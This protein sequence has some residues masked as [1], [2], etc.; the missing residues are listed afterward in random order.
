MPLS[1]KQK[2]VLGVTTIVVLV[3]IGLSV[4][5]IGTL[6]RVLLQQAATRAE[7][8]AASVVHQTGG[9]VLSRETAYQDIRSSATVLSALESAMYSPE[10]Q[11]AAILDLSRTVV[12]ANDPA[13]V[14]RT[15]ARGEDLPALVVASGYEQVRAVY[16]QGR[17]LEWR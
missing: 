3:V 9:A 10:V 5:H 11:Y 13:Q 17:T 12:A 6:V 7:V 2:Q 1:I 14:G 16:T 15:L 4:L 8:V